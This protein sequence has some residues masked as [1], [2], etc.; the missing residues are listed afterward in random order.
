MVIAASVISFLAILLVP[1]LLVRFCKRQLAAFHRA[2]TNRIARP[3]AARLPGF[4]T[5]TNVGRKS[6]KLY[7]T[8]VNVF[9]KPD[10]FRI[11]LTYG[12]NSGWVS[13]VLASGGCRLE[14]RGLLYQLSAPVI[15]HDP[16]RRRF[17]LIVR[18]VLGLIDANDFLE[19]TIARGEELPS[20]RE[21]RGAHK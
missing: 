13:N 2:V 6:G 16:S 12:R 4:G 9:R 15:F 11:A 1:I 20:N 8:P 10:G 7:R 5:V 21:S 18:T 19:L 14:T 3:F 17:P